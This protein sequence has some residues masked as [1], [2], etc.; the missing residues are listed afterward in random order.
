MNGTTPKRVYVSFT[1]EIVPAT[2][3]ALLALA[4][5]LVNK[6][7]QELYLL[8]STPGGSVMPGIAAYN[9][10]KGLPLKLIV[11]NV[12]S[13]DSIGNVLFL[14][15]RE[16]YCCKRA[17]FMFH[18]VGF[19]VVERSRF[20]EKH[21]RERLDSVMADQKKIGAIIADRTSIGAE[22]V[23]QLFH[24]AVTRDPDY[25][26]ANGIVHDIREVE[27]PPGAPVHQLVFKR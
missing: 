4:T 23:D 20:E 8:L 9:I 3:E 15:G 1:A 27:V 26:K 24:E 7:V 2:I 6:G 5:D 12:G 13:V 17:T 19:D 10:L 18:G 16:R 11:H 22:E 25:A 21:L 14:A